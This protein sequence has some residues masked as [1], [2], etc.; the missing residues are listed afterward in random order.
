MKSV[1]D[2]MVPAIMINIHMYMGT[3]A[4]IVGSIPEKLPSLGEKSLS[5]FLGA[6]QRC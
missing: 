4:E 6:N 2:Q 5:S 3:E 1:L